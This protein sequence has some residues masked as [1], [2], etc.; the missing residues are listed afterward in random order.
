[1]PYLNW[2]ESV[3]AE[4]RQVAAT[5]SGEGMAFHWTWTLE[6]KDEFLL[7]I[8]ELLKLTRQQ[9][10]G[11]SVPELRIDLPRN[12]IFFL[13]LRESESRLLIAHPQVEEWV[14]SASLLEEHATVL[15]QRIQVAVQGDRFSL[16]SLF[17]VARLSNV[18]IFLEM[19]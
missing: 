13:K 19:I 17:R 2:R 9:A 15:I 12:W 10:V 7:G 11:L 1:M 5:T 6:R 3:Q 16:N 14:V 8:E 4:V 18:E